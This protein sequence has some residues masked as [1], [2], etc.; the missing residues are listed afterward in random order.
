MSEYSIHVLILFSRKRGQWH[1]VKYLDKT[2]TVHQTYKEKRKL[3]AY[4]GVEGTDKKRCL[5]C[6]D[7][8]VFAQTT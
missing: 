1:I 2:A 3:A 6:S 7:E 8:W 5:I 4:G